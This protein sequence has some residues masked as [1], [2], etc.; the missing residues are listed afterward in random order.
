MESLGEPGR[1]HVAE[2]AFERLKSGY[3]L[4][5]RGDIEVKGKGMMPTWYLEAAL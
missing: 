5:P 2:G 1:I 4:Q 3:R